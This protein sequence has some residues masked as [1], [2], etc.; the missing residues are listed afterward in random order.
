MMPHLW[1]LQGTSGS[2]STPELPTAPSV[3]NPPGVRTRE[4]LPAPG[5][6]APL[7]GLLRLPLELPIVGVVATL[8][9]LFELLGAVTR[10]PVCR[11]VEGGNTVLLPLPRRCAE[12]SGW[13]VRSWL[14][15][16]GAP[17]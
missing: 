3:R 5:P 1:H 8:G 16:D 14:V 11:S 6:T 4:A 15:G 2:S 13:G 12:P 10:E 9:V 17:A 7:R